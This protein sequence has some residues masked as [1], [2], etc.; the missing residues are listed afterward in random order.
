MVLLS[1][2]GL[3]RLHHILLSNP[4]W[5]SFAL[6]ALKVE[7]KHKK[8]ACG[9]PMAT[10]PTDSLHFRGTRPRAVAPGPDRSLGVEGWELLERVAEGTYSY[11]Y[12]AR[13]AD[14]C[15]PSPGVYAVKILREPWCDRPEIVELQRSEARVAC[16]VCNPHLISVLAASTVNKPYFLVSPWLEGQTLSRMLDSHRGIDL[17]NVLWIARQMAEALHALET[18]GWMHGDVKPGNLIVSPEA[19]VTLI[20]LGFAR[21]LGHGGS[22][23]DRPVMGTYQYIAPEMITSRLAADT[24]SD[25]YSL[26]VV[27]FQMLARRLPFEGKTLAE[28]AEKHRSW[29]PPNLRQLVPSLPGGLTRLVREMLSKNPWRRPRH[30]QEVVERL[31]DLEVATFAQRS[32]A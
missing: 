6:R 19:H 22:V 28:L 30:A 11:V 26:G 13:P 9:A 24:R 1:E 7:A 18:A 31:T 3:L 29:R 21:A 17:P 15:S 14:R 27:L 2:T 8:H 20:D 23:V 12:R 32:I 25:I 4:V 10:H 5:E 16:E